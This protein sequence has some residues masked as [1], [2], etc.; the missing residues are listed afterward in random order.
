[1]NVPTTTTHKRKGKRNSK[2]DFNIGV[3]VEP[4]D[5]CQDYS[6][7]DGLV[8]STEQDPP[9]KR[10]KLDKE[11]L[12]EEKVKEGRWIVHATPAANLFDGTITNLEH[13]S[14][15]LEGGIMA[16]GL[17]PMVQ[18]GK[19]SKKPIRGVWAVPGGRAPWTIAHIV[20]THGEALKKSGGKIA[21]IMIYADDDRI[22]NFIP[23][24]PGSKW[25]EL[26]RPA[27]SPEV[28]PVY[29]KD[30]FIVDIKELPLFLKQTKVCKDLIPLRTDV[31]KKATFDLWYNHKG[32]KEKSAKR[33]AEWYHN[34][35]G[36]D[37]Q[38]EYRASEKGQKTL[39]KRNATK[40]AKLSNIKG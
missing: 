22:K 18:K 30:V 16:Q 24:R 34:G 1:M 26:C 39:Q 35:G 9:A 38:A 14:F 8:Y 31:Q 32:G 17:Q 5:D 28:I 37:R 27:Y 7:S 12:D 10:L 13:H 19:K 20:R 29:P 33:S 21:L 40:R 3:Y 6:K 15:D 4:S 23:F 36:K 2:Y 25:S 11:P